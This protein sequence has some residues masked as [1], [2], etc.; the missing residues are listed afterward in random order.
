ME[1]SEVKASLKAQCA[2][3]L[4]GLLDARAERERQ[5]TEEEERIQAKLLAIG[6]CP[7]GFAWLKCD[8]GGW[9]CAGRSH[10]VSDEQLKREFGEE[11]PA[12]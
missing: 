2:Q 8:S 3:L 6:K 5:K 4:G 12:S 1:P 9:R 11:V 7:M 10:H